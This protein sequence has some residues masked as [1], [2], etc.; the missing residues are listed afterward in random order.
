MA[1][2]LDLQGLTT[3]DGNIKEYIGSQIDTKVAAAIS[4]VT[5]FNFE[6]V[7]GLPETGVKGTIYLVPVTDALQP[8][9]YDEYIYVEREEGDNWELIGNTRVDMTNYYTKTEAD[10]KFAGTST[11][12]TSAPG[13][14]SADDKIKLNG[15]ENYTLPSASATQ[16]GGIKVGTNLS[17]TSDG[18]LSAVDSYIKEITG[19]VNALEFTTNGHS[20][21]N[22]MNTKVVHITPEIKVISDVTAPTTGVKN[23]QGIAFNTKCFTISQSSGYGESDKFADVT[24]NTITD[25]EINNL[26]PE[27]NN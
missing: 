13:L 2:Y 4:G 23:V 27:Q 16:L 25:T 6:V 19:D 18:T 12:T 15:L 11:A 10:G 20:F 17:V 24:V 8:D 26:F 7:E 5:Q 21:D 9:S 1:K 3:Y 14:M 22:G